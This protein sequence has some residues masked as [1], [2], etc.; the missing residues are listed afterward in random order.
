MDMDMDR[1]VDMDLGMVMR[2]SKKSINYPCLGIDDA[3]FYIQQEL[4]I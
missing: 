1:D 2:Y 3:L 4:R